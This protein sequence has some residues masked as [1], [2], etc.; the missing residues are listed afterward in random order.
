[1]VED[2]IRTGKAASAFVQNTLH[3]N[4]QI[5]INAGV[6]FEHYTYDRNILR[7][8]FSIGGTSLVRDTNIHAG[9]QLTSLLP[10]VGINVN[11][12]K[13]NTLFAGLH[14]GFAPPRV[15]DAV[16]NQ[17]EVYALDAEQSWNTE[18]GTRGH[19]NHV[20]EYEITLFSMN[21]SNQIIPVSESS[22]GTGTGLVNGG[23]TL[24]QG[25]EIAYLLDM[26]KILHTKTK[27]TWKTNMTLNNAVFNQDRFI[28]VGAEV[29]NIKGNKT[30]Y[31]PEY[32]L[33]S[34]L[35]AMLKFG[36]G[37]QI[38]AQ[39]VGAQYTDLLNTTLPSAD[40]RIGKLQAYQIFDVNLYYTI[41]KTKVT[42]NTAVKNMTNERFITSR[43]PQGIRVGNPRFLSVGVDVNF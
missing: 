39:W 21:F 25:I 13:N 9:N 26:G 42:F 19:F 37:A 29:V 32:Y 3:V 15:K 33:T 27:L 5:A 10:G 11:I 23:Q 30:P 6:R 4:R 16:S 8:S 34:A 17:G 14:R 40:G 35:N 38:T 24:H 2:E 28:K 41:P 12:S 1:M 22:G 36:L 20:L 43:R 7:N 31:A 18:I